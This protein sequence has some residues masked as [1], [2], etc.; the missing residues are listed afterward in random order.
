MV[1]QPTGPAKSLKLEL[2]MATQ[3]RSVAAARLGDISCSELIA[4]SDPDICSTRENCQAL[5]LTGY[6]LI[7]HSE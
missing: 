7:R 2:L 1:V 6:R 5:P 3:K 4:P